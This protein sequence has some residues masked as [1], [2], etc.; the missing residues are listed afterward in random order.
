MRSIKKNIKKYKNKSR[1]KRNKNNTKKKYRS[2]L[3]KSKKKGGSLPQNNIPH[4]FEGDQAFEIYRDGDS[5]QSFLRSYLD[6]EKGDEIKTGSKLIKLK[7][8]PYKAKYNFSP[9]INYVTFTLENGD[10]ALNKS[11]KFQI[12]EMNTLKNYMIYVFNKINIM[13]KNYKKID[14]YDNFSKNTEKFTISTTKKKKK[15]TNNT[16]KKKIKPLNLVLKNETKAWFDKNGNFYFKSNDNIFMSLFLS[17]FYLLEISDRLILYYYKI[18]QKPI[19]HHKLLKFNFEEMRIEAVNKNSFLSKMLPGISKYFNDAVDFKGINFFEQQKNIYDNEQFKIE[20]LHYYLYYILIRLPY[21]LLDDIKNEIIKI[22]REEPEQEPE[23]EP[24]PILPKTNEIPENQKFIN[25]ITDFDGKRCRGELA[26]N[27]ESEYKKNYS[28]NFYNLIFQKLGGIEAILIEDKIQNLLD[29]SEKLKIEAKKAKQAYQNVNTK[30]EER[31]KKKKEAVEA[32]QKANE[33]LKKANELLTKAKGQISLIPQKKNFENRKSG[34]YK[35]PH[36]F[37][38]HINSINNNKQ[39][40]EYLNFFRT[41]YAFRNKYTAD[42]LAA[43]KEEETFNED[44]IYKEFHRELIR[45]MSK[46]YIF[47]CNID[48][49]RE[50][51]FLDENCLDSEKINF[52]KKNLITVYYSIGEGG[53]C[54][55]RIEGKNKDGVFNLTVYTE[56]SKLNEFLES[57]KDFKEQNK[58]QYLEDLT[59]EKL[60]NIKT[61][62]DREDLANDYGINVEY[63]DKLKKYFNI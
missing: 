39:L 1:I 14:K 15:Q 59:Y 16:K 8:K 45:I 47:K 19:K 28:E 63:I 33:L 5:L 32:K 62:K 41:I 27:T 44:K 42:R 61:S 23:Q 36:D 54:W 34:N 43:I 2:I 7:I 22:I 51:Q 29:E 52:S 60:K 10:E 48:D 20:N 49:P 37:P 50:G 11:V 4:N 35:L 55:E 38:P 46:R 56:N 12:E 30:E 17:Y 26:P 3:K 18:K 9:G 57:L 53:A 6:Q 40:E 58:T 25:F 13:I 24:E 21:N 31:K